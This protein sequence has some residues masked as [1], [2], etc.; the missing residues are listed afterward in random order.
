MSVLLNV[1]MGLCS[2]YIQQAELKFE[3]KYAR[4]SSNYIQF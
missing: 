3:R 4:I 1:N 2:F